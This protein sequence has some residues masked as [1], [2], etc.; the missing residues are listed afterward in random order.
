[1]DY[2]LDLATRFF[3]RLAEVQEVEQ[4]I[5]GKPPKEVIEWGQTEPP[6]IL[7]EFVRSKPDR[8]R[9]FLRPARPASLPAW[10]SAIKNSAANLKIL[11][12]MVKK[13]FSR[14]EEKPSTLAQPPDSVRLLATELHSYIKKFKSF[15]RRITAFLSEAQPSVQPEPDRSAT[16]EKSDSAQSRRVKR[17]L[18]VWEWKDERSRQMLMEL[19][20]RDP[21]IAADIASSGENMVPGF[22]TYLAEDT[23]RFL[24]TWAGLH[25]R[26]QKELLTAKTGVEQAFQRE[27]LN[28]PRQST[29]KELATFLIARPK[30][31]KEIALLVK[32]AVP[33][34]LVLQTEIEEIRESR[35]SRVD[36]PD[37]DA[38]AAILM[39]RIATLRAQATHPE[40]SKEHIDDREGQGYD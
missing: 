4:E 34:S 3:R 5:L 1:M 37:Y 9:V 6:N 13:V 22:V 25:W 18:D 16:P 35:L 10:R 8:V 32:S 36:K 23:I 19:M 33:F 11:L 39:Y 29:P 15:E 27:G 14:K 7:V 2:M 38:Q 28:Y 26:R 31:V 20:Y 24:N 21:Q 40:S 30:L 12:L 17:A